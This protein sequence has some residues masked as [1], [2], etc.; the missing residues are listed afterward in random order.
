MHKK[1]PK[2][3]L[4][5]CLKEMYRAINCI[6]RVSRERQCLKERWKAMKGIERVPREQ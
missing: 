6:E 2:G 4:L 5:H 3:A 1:S